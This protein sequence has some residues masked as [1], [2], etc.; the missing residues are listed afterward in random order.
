MARNEV[1]AYSNALVARSERDEATRFC[2]NF[3]HD[4]SPGERRF[5]GFARNDAGHGA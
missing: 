1:S 2:T 3:Y 4:T 5:L